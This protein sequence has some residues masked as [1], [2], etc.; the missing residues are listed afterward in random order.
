MPADT[1]SMTMDSLLARIRQRVTQAG[2]QACLVADGTAWSYA[3]MWQDAR[4]VASFLRGKGLQRGDRVALVADNSPQYVAVF[5]G[6]LL[7]G[8]AVVP[9]NTNSK[10]RDFDNW[11]AHCGAR[12]AFVDFT[13]REMQKLLQGERAVAFIA[14]Q[15]R[16]DGAIP[17]P[18]RAVLLADWSD[19][20]STPVDPAIDEQDASA[21]DLACIIYTS[22]T[23]GNPKGVKISHGNL[24]A[25]VN[26][27]LAA[28]PIQPGDRFL[29]V[30]PFYYSYGNSVLHTHIVQ[31][32]TLY[33]ENSLMYPHSVVARLQ[34]EAITGFA[35]VPSTFALLLSRG[36]VN[37]HDLSSLRYVLQAGGAM[38]VP[39]IREVMEKMS[40]SLYVMYG[41]TEATAR[42]TCLPPER[43]EKKLGSVGLPIQG[44]TI[45]IRRPDGTLCAV[46]EEGEL[47]AQG[48]N[49][50]QGYWDNANATA[51]TFSNGWLKTGDLG[52]CDADGFLFLQGRRSDMIK[53]G[54]NR[55]SPLEIE[56]VI[57]EIPTIEEVAVVGLPDEVLGQTIAAFVV[58]KEGQAL[59]IKAIKKYCLDNLASYKIP[60]QILKVDVL[61]KT[62]S[63]KIRK[64]LL[65]ELIEDKS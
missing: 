11:M 62:A 48:G 46:G 45:E 40:R 60:K 59:D 64:H 38:T 1:G 57:S 24:L 47:Y 17:E 16:A 25:N 41:Q 33:L 58:M 26:S 35:G 7:A 15:Q 37:E 5:Y 19:I 2:E 65:A 12:F 63:G 9:M 34:N 13:P 54:A 10:L 30:L 52:R 39:L 31:G 51:E 23:T 29:N 50:A 55:I 27:I 21:D 4:R 43:L 18:Q 28:L 49:V 14:T 3:D 42:L 8:G 36:K 56:E 22:G 44:V 53:S 20:Q 32:A 6:V 61:P